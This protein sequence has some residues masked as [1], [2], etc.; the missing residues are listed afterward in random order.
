LQELPMEKS[1]LFGRPRKEK[2]TGSLQYPE[3]YAIMRIKKIQVKYLPESSINFVI[4][5]C[6]KNIII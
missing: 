1:V 4:L 2:C 3:K 5:S 6:I